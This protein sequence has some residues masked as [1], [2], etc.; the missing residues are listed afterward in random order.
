MYHWKK[1]VAHF[2]QFESAAD[3]TYTAYPIQSGPIFK[4]QELSIKKY[5]PCNMTDNTASLKPVVESLR[6]LEQDFI[7]L[8]SL[9]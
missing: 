4:N 5:W 6:C 9:L 8:I 2:L 1:N 7:S 3:K